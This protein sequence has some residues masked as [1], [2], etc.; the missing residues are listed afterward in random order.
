MD[1]HAGL[2]NTGSVGQ[3]QFFPAAYGY[4]G[5]N[6]DFALPLTVEFQ[7]FFSVVHKKYRLSSFQKYAIYYIE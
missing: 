4:T 3:G 6:F 2:S 1:S 5:H 7:G